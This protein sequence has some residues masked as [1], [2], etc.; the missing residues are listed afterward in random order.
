MLEPSCGDGRILDELAARGCRP[1][2]IEVHAGRA[3][4]ARAKGHAVL[5]ANFLEQ[6]AKP[7]FDFVVMNPPFSGS[8][9]KKHLAHARKFLKPGGSLACILPASAWYDHGG[10]DGTWHDLPVASFAE[11]GTN[12]PTG[13]LIVRGQQ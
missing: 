2:G 12:V 10:L 7:D 3:A 5:V 1:L 4:Q 8:H 6:P 9:W 13:Y 11:S